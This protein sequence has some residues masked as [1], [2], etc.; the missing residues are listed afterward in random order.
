MP[1]PP[2]SPSPHVFEHPSS[3]GSFRNW[4]KL[5]SASQG[6]DREYLL[7]VFFVT[8]SNL[9]T[10]PFRLYEHLRYDRL[11]KGTEINPSPIF[12][13]GHWRTGTTHLQ[14]LL[15]RDANL[16]WVSTFQC[17]APGFSLSGAKYLK[18]TI[19]WIS[20]CLHPTRLIDNIPLLLDAPQEEDFALANLSPYSFIHMFTFPRQA[21]EFF[22]RYALLEGLSEDL[23]AKWKQSYLHILTKA[24][25]YSGGKRLILK[26]PA[27]S[28][29]IQTI[30]SIFPDA[31]FIHICRDPYQVFLSMQKVYQTVLPR[32]QV[33]YI[34]S[35]QVDE[36]ILDFYV[37]LMKKY[38]AKKTLIS[39]Q[40]LVEIRFEDLETRPMEQLKM[41]YEKLDLPGFR[42]VEP[43]LQD[44]LAAI[45]GYQKNQYLLT[46]EIIARV[47][48]KWDF[49]F[50]TWG[51]PKRMPGT[52]P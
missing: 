42:Q 5:L 9:A 4:M 43:A 26:G 8:L 46:D 41:I 28:G 1:T 20:S 36:L 30:L 7:R 47:N 51:Y 25:Y 24:T 18:P 33:Q 50:E 14:N 35:E 6:I 13:L 21:R 19:Q 2:L 40:A 37:R 49:A 32:A 31:R 34:D 44:Y 45:K 3:L 15:C 29:R 39:P 10:S 11:L 12:I 48:Q 27:N 22:T 52:S 17:L 23:L 16:G 38:L